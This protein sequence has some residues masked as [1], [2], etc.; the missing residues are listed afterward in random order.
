MS[1]STILNDKILEL[2]EELEQTELEKQ[3]I[4]QAFE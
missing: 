3:N 2:M 1:N 4:S